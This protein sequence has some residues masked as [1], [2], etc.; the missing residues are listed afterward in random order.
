MVNFLRRSV[1]YLGTAE[2]TVLMGAVWLGPMPIPLFRITGNEACRMT[3]LL[4]LWAATALLTA[5]KLTWGALPDPY[6]VTHW[7]R[8]LI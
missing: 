1:R 8:T 2:Y 5:A 4:V 3:V 6:S 7:V